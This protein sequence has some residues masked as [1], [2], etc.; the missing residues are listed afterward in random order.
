V[1]SDEAISLLKAYQKFYLGDQPE[2]WDRNRHAYRTEIE[3]MFQENIALLH[4]HSRFLKELADYV[5][6]EL[7]KS[8]PGDLAR[9]TSIKQDVIRAIQTDKDPT[10][11][12]MKHYIEMQWS[13]VSG[14]EQTKELEFREAISKSK[15]A[16]GRVSIYQDYY[17]G[18]EEDDDH[19][20]RHMKAKYSSM[21]AEGHP[22][23]EVIQQWHREVL[24]A[25]EKDT[26][27]LKNHLGELKMA[28]TAHLKNKAKKAENQ[29]MWDQKD[30]IEV[31]KKTFICSFP[32]C[33]IDLV[34]TAQES[35]ATCL[36][37][38]WLAIR[39]EEVGAAA[40]REPPYYC[41]VEHAEADFNDHDQEAH[42]CIMGDDCIEHSRHQPEDS[43]ERALCKACLDDHRL[44]LFCSFA[45]YQIN[46]DAHLKDMHHQQNQQE[47]LD[48]VEVFSREEPYSC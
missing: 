19:S 42:T 23:D 35:W 11:S 30:E 14:S 34:D 38:E 12:A 45:C 10:S 40:G 7:C 6:D 47:E 20:K 24:E 41:T 1:Q 8:R 36:Y 21:F 27:K 2:R 26:A 37:C 3:A 18:Y 32:G 22:H 9:V 39:E 33:G 15:S 29:R 46:S 25:Q 5:T 31:D 48:Q 28:Q 17:C 43:D 16:V 4:I 44:S 13:L